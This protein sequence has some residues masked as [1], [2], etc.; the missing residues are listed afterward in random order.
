LEK[1]MEFRNNYLTQELSLNEFMP[2]KD[3]F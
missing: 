1:M 3:L 2:W